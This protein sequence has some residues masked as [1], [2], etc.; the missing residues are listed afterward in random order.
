MIANWNSRVGTDDVIYILG[1]VFFCDVRE[2]T[3]IMHA[4]NGRKRLILGNHDKI[5]RKNSSL[6]KLFEVIY[7][8]LWHETIDKKYVVMCH[9]PLLS[10]HRAYHGSFMLHGHCH[11][12]IPFDPTKRRL[13]VGV[14]GHNYFPISWEEVKRKLDKLSPGDA[15]D[16]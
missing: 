8:D 13:D 6:Q 9:Y 2:A 10:W 12:T 14:D 5:I 11:N 3:S 7:P 16:Y 15:R 1:D 4:L